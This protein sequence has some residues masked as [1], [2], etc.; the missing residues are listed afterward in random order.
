MTIDRFHSLFSRRFSPRARAVIV[1]ERCG[2]VFHCYFSH[3][4][5][6]ASCFVIQE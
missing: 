4:R 2:D 3:E 6:L 1:T 5:R